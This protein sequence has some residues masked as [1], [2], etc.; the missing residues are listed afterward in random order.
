MADPG[1]LPQ[2]SPRRAGRA[3]P[4]TPAQAPRQSPA[5][6][7]T[8]D[9]P[10]QGRP[11]FPHRPAPRLAGGDVVRRP[12]RRRGRGGHRSAPRGQGIRRTDGHRAVSSSSTRRGGPLYREGVSVDDGPFRVVS[13]RQV[14]VFT[15]VRE[16]LTRLIEEGGF[17]AGDRLPA[18]RV[19][20]ERLGVSR[21]MVREAMRV[22]EAAGR[23][24]IVHGAGTFV[25]AP[26]HDPIVD[27]L[28]AGAELNT[29]FLRHLVDLRAGLEVKIVALAVERADDADLKALQDVLDRLEAEHLP[30]PEV[31]SLN[32]AFEA[33]L[34]SATHNPLLTR[35][36]AAVHE[37]WIQAWGSL[38]L[39]PG[40]KQALHDEHVAMYRA[41]VRRDAE[42]ATRMMHDHVERFRRF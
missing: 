13:L 38:H 9:R 40:T 11:C 22:L 1:P 37:L 17:Q 8:A 30:G 31:G 26:G 20:A 15:A 41:L 36:Q 2:A 16:E 29:T 12:A 25:R 39:A 18:E 19:L 33:A 3:G 4:R 21:S 35:L 32:V 10:R 14:D 7:G 28:R 5:A 24:E 27:A 23:V 6:H 42:A 34:G